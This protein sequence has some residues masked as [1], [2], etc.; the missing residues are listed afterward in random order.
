MSSR[1]D[2][3]VFLKS[4]NT[5][6]AQNIW[7]IIGLQR[8]SIDGIYNCWVIVS[9]MYLPIKVQLNRTIYIHST[10]TLNIPNFKLTKK[11]LPRDKVSVYL[12]EFKCVE[13]QF[14]KRYAEIQKLMSNAFIEGI[15][16]SKIPLEFKFASKIGNFCRLKNG[17]ESKDGVWNGDDLEEIN[18]YQEDIRKY[19]DA[20]YVGIFS[21]GSNNLL[22][23]INEKL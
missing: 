9:G 4:A 17:A 6:L 22:L 8:T 14:H 23:V 10:R 13:S 3:D 18:S 2:I 21:Y 16:E 19:V 15:Y 20:V 11:I 1:R 7:N 12:Y 5:F